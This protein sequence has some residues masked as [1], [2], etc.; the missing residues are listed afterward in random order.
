[1]NTKG[2]YML[3][4]YKFDR[5]GWIIFDTEENCKNAMT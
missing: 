5:I 1:M 3:K 4:L 2:I